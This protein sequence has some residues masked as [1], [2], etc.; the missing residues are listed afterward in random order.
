[1]AGGKIVANGCAGQLAEPKLFDAMHGQN[2]YPRI[3]IFVSDEIPYHMFCLNEAAARLPR[4]PIN[5]LTS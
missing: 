4:Q 5:Y 2:G 3:A 1:L